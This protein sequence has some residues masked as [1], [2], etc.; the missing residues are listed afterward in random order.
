M[1]ADNQDTVQC[2]YCKEAVHPDAVKCKH[3]HARLDAARKDH[4]GTCPFCKEAIHPEAI[5]CKHCQSMLTGSRASEAGCG[6]GGGGAADPALRMALARRRAP[7]GT[8]GG[9]VNEELCDWEC[10]WEWVDC[11]D[12]P[13]GAGAPGSDRRRRTCDIKETLCQIFCQA[14]W[15]GGGGVLR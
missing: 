6:C 14:G 1:P 7:N 8:G 15:G 4:G 13:L 5:K 9:G 11:M 2:P 12:S 3:C 10:L